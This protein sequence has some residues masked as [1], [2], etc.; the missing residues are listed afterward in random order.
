[1]STTQQPVHNPARP[2]EVTLRDNRSRYSDVTPD[3]LKKMYPSD[4]WP[5]RYSKAVYGWR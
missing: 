1:M 3:K 5:L 4:N 2:G